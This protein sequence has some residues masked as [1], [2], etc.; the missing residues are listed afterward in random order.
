MQSIGLLR[1]EH[2]LIEKVAAC[3]DRAADS[4][5]AGGPVHEE[6][7]LKTLEFI[8]GLVHR[9]HQAREEI[10]SRFVIERCRMEAEVRPCSDLLDF[11]GAI[12]RS[13]PEAAD[14][15]PAA[16]RLLSENAKAYVA[17]VRSNIRSRRMLFD[18]VERSLSE[19]DDRTLVALFEEAECRLGEGAAERYGR[20]AD[21]IEKRSEAPARE[22]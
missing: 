13:L 12:L 17:L 22:G 20:L 9:V 3:L 11:S 15:E 16:R 14:G 6:F 19:G 4:V 18:T 1:H 2:A 7:F 21:A 8:N 10:L 5:Q